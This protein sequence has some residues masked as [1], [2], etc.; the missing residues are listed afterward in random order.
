MLRPLKNVSGNPEG[1]ATKDNDATWK[2]VCTLGGY[3][4]RAVYDIDWCHHTD[5]IVTAAGD[6]MI[7]YSKNEA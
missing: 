3:H 7:R 2:C 4:T 1:V 6:D 5:L